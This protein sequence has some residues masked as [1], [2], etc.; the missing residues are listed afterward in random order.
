MSLF[1]LAGALAG[2]GL[3]LDAVGIIIILANMAGDFNRISIRTHATGM[4]VMAFGGL[5]LLAGFIAF[6]GH[7]A[8]AI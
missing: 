7:L 2:F 3:L 5:S 1:A 4:G 8:Q 6:C